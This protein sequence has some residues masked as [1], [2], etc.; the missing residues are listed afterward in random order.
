MDQDKRTLEFLKLFVRHE[1]EIYAYILALVPNVHDADDLFQEG[2]TVMWKKFDQFQS[3]TNFAGWGVKIMRYQ[4]LDYRR[5]LA[6]SKRVLIDDSL[7]DVLMDYI[8]S[9]QNEL[10]E[11]IDALGKCQTLLDNRFKKIIKMRYERNTPVEEIASYLK[12][13]RRHIYHILGKINGMLLKCMR[14]TMSERP[15]VYE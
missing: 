5:K 13:S 7:F 10:A 4:I 6:R 2:M 14:R 1:Q 15:R 11:R 9:I 3:G 12:L 8:P